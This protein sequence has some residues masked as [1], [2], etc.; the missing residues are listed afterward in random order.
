M[1][2]RKKN[3]EKPAQINQNKSTFHSP[4]CFIYTKDKRHNTKLYKQT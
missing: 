2:K 3:I 4:E 1:K